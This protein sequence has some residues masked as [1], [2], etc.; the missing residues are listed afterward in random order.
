MHNPL[1]SIIVP[2]YGVER[3]IRK[4]LDSLVNQTYHNLE[5]ILVDD[6]S[7]DGCGVICDEYAEKDHRIR[8]IHKENGGV[9]SA[10]NA[11]LAMI[12]G[13]WIGWVDPDDWIERDMF[14][15]MLCH[16]ISSEADVVVCGRY[17]EF[18]EK[19]RFRGWKEKI[20]F[21]TEQVL[22]ALLDDQTLQNFLWDKL[23]KRELFDDVVF[24][25]G[26]VFEDISVIFGILERTKKVVCLPEAKYH[27]RQ[28]IGSI[29]TELSL[30]NKMQCY[31]A[32]KQR[33]SQPSD[34]WPQ[35]REKLQIKCVTTGIS[36]W[37]V[38]Y[39]S[40]REERRRFWSEIKEISDF[41]RLHYRMVLEM[42]DLG[43]IGR[44]V[45]WLTRYPKWWAF[46]ISMFCGK[47]YMFKHGRSL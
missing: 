7:P 34:R 20:S 44:I 35:F 19:S 10:R 22:Q 46:L 8:V 2:I 38:Y 14:E 13:Q 32:M 1:I 27:Y 9:S 43:V 39:F 3:Y 29:T 37:C 12:T 24:P 36:V 21:D 42:T 6:G 26:R 25:E 16:A 40:S 45:L 23:W 4:C 17:E 30:K 5:F 41:S 28:R 33:L 47:V 15:Y 11:G 31:L 18:S